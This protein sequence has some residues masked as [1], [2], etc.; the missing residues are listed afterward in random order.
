[1]SSET[2]DF[3]SFLAGF[4]LGGLVGAAAALILAPQSGLETR[5]QLIEKSHAFRSQADTYRSEYQARAQEYLH[6]AQQQVSGMTT[7]PPMQGN[8]IILDDGGQMPERPDDA[9]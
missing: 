1:M 9:R 7:T 5:H 6:E 4:V 8:N 3:S 2:G